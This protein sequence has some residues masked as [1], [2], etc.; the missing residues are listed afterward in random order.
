MRYDLPKTVEIGG[1]HYA[2][3][4][5]FRDVLE[6]FT[7]LADPM[8]TD[9]SK[10]IVTLE[11]LYPEAET[12]PPENIEEAL[13]QASW[14]INGGRDEDAA[15]AKAPKLVAWEQDF[16]HIIAPINRVMGTD[17]RAVKNMHWWTFLAAYME[18]GDCLFAQIVRIR[19][20]RARGKPLDKFEKEFLRRNRDLVDIKKTYTTA[21]DDLVRMWTKG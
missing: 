11:I 14:F 17:I 15:K 8:L 18:I 13:R 12:I 4:T 21:E 20:K 6:L 16:P 2:I 9:R 19:D 1:R 7:V 3:R 5:D 10:A